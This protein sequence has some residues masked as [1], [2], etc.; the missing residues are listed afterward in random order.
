MF[1]KL[2]KYVVSVF[3]KGYLW[4]KGRMANRIAVSLRKDQIA[5][6]IDVK[7][8]GGNLGEKENVKIN[9]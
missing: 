7:E 4:G 8:R 2:N 3:V 6:S 9:L 1:L 5:Y